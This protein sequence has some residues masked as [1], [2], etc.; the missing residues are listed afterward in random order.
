MEQL[1]NGETEFVPSGIQHLQE[2]NDSNEASS[3]KQ[4]PEATNFESSKI[5]YC[6]NKRNFKCLNLK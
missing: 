3:S 4:K 2:A 6:F 5:I 1:V